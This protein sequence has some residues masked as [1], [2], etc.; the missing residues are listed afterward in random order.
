MWTPR[1][2]GSQSGGLFLAIVSAAQ[3][4]QQMVFERSGV[5]FTVNRFFIF[6][7]SW[8]ELQQY[9]NLI[10]VLKQTLAGQD[11]SERD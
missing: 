8:R 10:R 1:L 5:Q 11:L 4:G 7:R 2:L 9:G 3:F 6:G